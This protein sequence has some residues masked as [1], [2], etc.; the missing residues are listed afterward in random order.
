MDPIKRKDEATMQVSYTMKISHTMK[1]A[2]ISTTPQTTVLEAAKLLIKKRIGTLPV[3]DGDHKLI[4]MITIDDVLDVF[5]PNYFGLIENLSFVH[6]FGALEDFQPK[7]FSEVDEVTVETLMKTPVFV[8]ETDSIFRA[9]TTLF[10]HELIDLPVVD[11]QGK[12]VGLAS[13]VDVGTAFLR[14]W[15]E[16]K[17]PR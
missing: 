15:L 11:S 8:E 17:E 12:L 1:K 2:V 7:D 9:A 13:H 5:I 16:L 14:K 10:R 3:V 4:G 6:G